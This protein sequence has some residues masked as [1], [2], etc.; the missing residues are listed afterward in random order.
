MVL[1]AVLPSRSRSESCTMER[2]EVVRPTLLCNLRHCDFCS[3]PAVGERLAHPPLSLW[4]PACK[5]LPYSHAPPAQNSR[6]E[7]DVILVSQADRPNKV[8]FSLSQ[9]ACKVHTVL[10]SAIFF[11]LG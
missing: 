3:T 10:T 8:N 4:L 9:F 1:Q 11:E 5:P 6:F 7:H 2:D